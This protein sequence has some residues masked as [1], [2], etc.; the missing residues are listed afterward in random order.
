MLQS[1]E[2]QRLRVLVV[3]EERPRAGQACPQDRRCALP[4]NRF[5]LDEGARNL[6]GTPA[7]RAGFGKVEHGRPTHEAVIRVLAGVEH[8][9]QMAERVLVTPLAERRSAARDVRGREQRP[10]VH[11]GENLL[12]TGDHLLNVG[13]PAQCARERRGEFPDE[14]ELELAAVAREACCLDTGRLPRTP[15]AG[16]C[17]GP[18]VMH[19]RLGEQSKPPLL[20]QAFDRAEE[21]KVN[22]LKRADMLNGEQLAAELGLSRATV[23]NRRQEGKLLALEFGTKRGFRF[24]QWQRDLVEER[25][26]RASFEAVLN[27]LAPVEPWSRYRFFVQ[28]SP[29]LDGRTVRAGA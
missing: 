9:P 22:L 26:V 12:R 27:R 2:E 7:T 3:G 19:E 1:R 17:C 5:E 23:D 11:C 29:E 16:M 28:S 24:P 25:D 8:R 20:A 15:V 4:R 13:I 10:T 14:S 6:I 21:R 18:G